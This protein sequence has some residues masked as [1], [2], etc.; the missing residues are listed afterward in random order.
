MDPPAGILEPEQHTDIDRFT[1][2]FAQAKCVYTD[3]ITV[4]VTGG[5]TPV[6]IQTRR[7]EHGDSKTVQIVLDRPLTIDQTTTFTFNDAAGTASGTAAVNVTEYTVRISVSA[8]GLL[9]L[10]L[11]I[12]TA[13]TILLRRSDVHHRAPAQATLDSA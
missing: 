4:E 13:A 11:L 12:L 10:T 9:V 3:D 8:W 1:V 5:D 2:T 7:L 6:V